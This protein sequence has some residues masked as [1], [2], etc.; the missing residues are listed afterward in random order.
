M[1][2]VTAQTNLLPREGE[3]YY[4]GSIIPNQQS[5]HFFERLMTR[6]ACD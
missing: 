3:V 6:I 2:Q 1:G 4:F 5:D